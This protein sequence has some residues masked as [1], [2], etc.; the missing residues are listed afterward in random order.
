MSV[1]SPSGGVGAPQPE[2]SSPTGLLHVSLDVSAVPRQPV[3]AGHYTIELARALARRPDLDLTLWSRRSDRARWAEVIGQPGPDVPGPSA[4]GDALTDPGGRR[5]RVVRPSAPDRR[6]GR[7]AWEQLSLGRM[8]GRAAVAVHH[9]PHYTMPGHAGVPVVVTIHDLT[10]FDHPEWHERVKVPVF[11]HAIRRAAAHARALVCVSEHTAERLGRH[12][13]VRGKVFVVPH[14]VDHS[15]F[16]PDSPDEAADAAAIEATGIAGPFVLFLG[17]LEPRKAVPDLVRA[18]AKV[19]ARRRLTLVL[20]GQPGWGA[21]EV[22]HAVAET[23]M[24]ARVLRTGYVQDDVVPALL[25]R[26][27]AVVY[28]AREEGFGLPALEALA[29]GAPLVTTAGTVMAELAGSAAW[30]VPP[31]D[32]DLLAGAIEAALAD[33]ADVRRRRSAGLAVAASHTWARSAE[34]HMA[35]YRWAAARGPLSRGGREQDQ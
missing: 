34:G 21:A 35:A 10:F 2:P 31:G 15:R 23:N 6:L 25:R 16:R 29:C 26:A 5:R 33:D 7:L 19:A 9:G 13:E 30:L 8:V 22:D 14:G 27:A 24:A 4:R 28:P 1:S 32:V 18:F 20:A 12:V 17:T 3:G 11:R